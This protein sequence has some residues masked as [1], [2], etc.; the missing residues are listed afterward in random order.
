MKRHAVLMLVGLGAY[1]AVL[2][3]LPWLAVGPLESNV[4]RITL[5]LLP[6]LPV[7]FLCGVIIRTIRHMDELQR[8]V[9]FEAVALAFTG[10]ALIT[11]GYGFLEDAGLPRLSM[12]VVWP[13][14]AIL[15]AVGVIIGRVRYG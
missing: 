14:M 1:V 7:V 8:K 13:L 4:G 2:L 9:Q 11:F 15:W 12:F 10:T 3:T 5:A 6:M